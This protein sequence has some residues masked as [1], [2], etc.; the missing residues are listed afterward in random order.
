MYELIANFV[1]L[2]RYPITIEYKEVPSD[3]DPSKLVLKKFE[4]V[5]EDLFPLHFEIVFKLVSTIEEIQKREGELQINYDYVR[6][7]PKEIKDM[8]EASQ[9]EEFKGHDMVP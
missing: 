3:E 6:A 8:S 1:I 4:K 2:P 7:L 9:E 5:E